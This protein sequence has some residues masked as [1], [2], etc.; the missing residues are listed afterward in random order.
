MSKRLYW[1]Y[2]EGVY[3]IRVSGKEWSGSRKRV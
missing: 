1:Y 2:M 3:E